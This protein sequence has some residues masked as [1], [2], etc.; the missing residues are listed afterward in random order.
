MQMKTIARG[1]LV[2]LLSSSLLGACSGGSITSQQQASDDEANAP[3]TATVGAFTAPAEASPV[4][5]GG[6]SVPQGHPRLWWNA[7]RLARA[8]AWY[9]ANPF[10]PRASDPQNLALHYV[11]SG[12]TGSARAAINWLMGLTFGVGGIASDPAR[13][14]GENAILVFDWCHDQMTPAERATIIERW[15]GYITAL[16]D[17]TWGA[18]GME[19]NNYYWG[20]LRNGIEWGIATYH[21]NPMAEAILSRAMNTRWAQSFVPY[22]ATAG[23]G[24]ATHEGS[25]YGRYT[26]SYA[27]IPLT[28]ASLMGFDMWNQTPF[29]KEAVFPVIY[30]STPGKTIRKGT[31]EARYEVFPSNDDE[32]FRNGGSAESQHYGMFLSTMMDRY[33]GTPMAAWAKAW[34]DQVKPP[35]PEMY[36]AANASTTA[37]RPLTELPLDYHAPGF[38]LFSTRE[39]WAADTTMA[40]MQLGKAVGV[41]HEHRDWGT[42]QLW[43]NGRWL[44]RETTGYE[45]KIVGWRGASTNTTSPVAHNGILFEGMSLNSFQSRKGPPRTVRMESRPAYSLAAVDLTDAYRSTEAGRRDNAHVGRVVREFLFVRPLE[46]MVVFDRVASTSEAKP[47]N[48]VLKSFLL[49][50]ETPPQIEGNR[51]LAVNGDQALRVTT[52]LPAAPTYQVVDEG[53][54]IGQHRLEIEDKGTAESYFLNVL[55]A[56]GAADPDLKVEMTDTGAAFEVLLTHPTRG[57][58]KIVLA[59]GMSSVGGAFGYDAGGS[60]VTAPLID[61]VQTM[62]V[63][64]NGPVWQP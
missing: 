15:N 26:L 8:K 19:G 59:K 20:Y 36:A 43:R 22:A 23:A 1:G 7:E 53:G 46:T 41:G 50:F 39:R 12:D 35:V 4:K 38:G 57:T 33:P 51:V 60:P 3:T 37:A 24:G 11:V 16:E 29:F 61:R 47:A 62:T 28:S 64:E 40:S 49:H 32:N 31:N 17:K 56:R 52:L 55:Q 25:Q 42:F 5:A 14:H 54:K 21:E 34:M 9:A 58:A 6:L 27:T 45:D 63:N 10:T 44:T 48:D 13:W 30:G 18:T 2:A